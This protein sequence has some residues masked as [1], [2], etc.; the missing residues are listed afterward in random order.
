MCAWLC[1]MDKD[2]NV[3]VSWEE[4]RDF[5]LLQSH[6]SMRDIFRIWSHATVEYM[7]C[8]LLVFC[9]AVLGP[10]W[11]LDITLLISFLS[12]SL[13]LFPPLSSATLAKLWTQ[14]SCRMILPRRRK[15]RECGGGSWL[16]E[17]GQEQ[18][19]I[20]ARALTTISRV[21]DMPE[22]S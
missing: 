16:Q 18:V 9:V 1:R 4:W 22:Y 15:C 21:L 5:L 3:R 17:E 12:L 6:T 19:R 7:H 20:F 10:K 11:L 13:S 8:S 2:G 14:S